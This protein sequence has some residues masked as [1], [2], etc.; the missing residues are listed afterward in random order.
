MHDFR[1]LLKTIFDLVEEACC[2]AIAKQIEDPVFL[3]HEAIN[4]DGL[5]CSF[6]NLELNEYGDFY[7]VAMVD[8]S[9][10]E[11]IELQKFIHDYVLDRGYDVR[12]E[13]EW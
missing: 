12:I 10:P 7:F 9:A 3:D 2:Q 6:V 13:T 8:E 1:V 4:W 11:S 5:G